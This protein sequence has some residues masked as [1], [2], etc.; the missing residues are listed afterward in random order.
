MPNEREFV[1]QQLS[2]V[3]EKI[4]VI[5]RAEN[6]RKRRQKK[7]KVRRNFEKDRLN[8]PRN[9]LSERKTSSL[10]YRKRTW[11]DTFEKNIPTHSL[12]LRWGVLMNPIAH[13][14]RKKNLTI[15]LWN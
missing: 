12:T 8:S 11:K 3:K 6:A 5:A 1:K 4:L 7:R 10:I 15:H 2:E 13:I 9:C 14:H